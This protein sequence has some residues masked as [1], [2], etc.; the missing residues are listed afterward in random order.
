MNRFDFKRLDLAGGVKLLLRYGIVGIVAG[1]LLAFIITPLM[2]GLTT[3]LGIA[4]TG[5]FVLIF[6]LFALKFHPGE[7]SLLRDVIPYVIVAGI[8]AGIISMT[9]FAFPVLEMPAIFGIELGMAIA[10]IF[11]LDT[12]VLNLIPG[13]R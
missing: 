8:V 1:L 11:V 5:F 10:L 4:I 7:E 2:T 6:Y 9:G 13:L 12:F 3:A